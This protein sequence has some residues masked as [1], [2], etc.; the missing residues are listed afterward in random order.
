MVERIVS[1]QMNEGYFSEAPISFR[2]VEIAKQ[3]FVE[4][5]NAFYHTRISYLTDTQ[6][7]S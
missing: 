5:L 1:T 3:V 4:R 6:P 7:Q 2:E